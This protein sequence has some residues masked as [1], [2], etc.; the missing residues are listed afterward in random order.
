MERNRVSLVETPLHPSLDVN[1]S[2]LGKFPVDSLK[3]NAPPFV[4]V[5]GIRANSLAGLFDFNNTSSAFL[6]KE[7][8]C[9]LIGAEML[10]RFSL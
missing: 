6:C 5:R 8:F 10:P 1:T 9:T 3:I 4:M 2:F 7:D